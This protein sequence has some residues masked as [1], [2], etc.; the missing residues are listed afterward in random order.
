M[1]EKYTEKARRVIFFSRYEAGTQGAQA[2]EPEHILLGIMRE[3][4]PLLQRLLPDPGPALD[5][6]HKQ[7]SSN[8]AQGPEK[9]ASVDMPLSPAAKQALMKASEASHR[10]GHGRIGPEHLLIGIV[11]TPQSDASRI[12]VELGVTADRIA[13]CIGKGPSAHPW[14][15]IFEGDER[16]D[17]GLKLK[18]L[19]D[20]LERRG[21]FTREE[22]AQQMMNR[23]SRTHPDLLF[24]VLLELLE[25]KK[26]ITTEEARSIREGS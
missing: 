7:I 15:T 20:L 9:P 13:A 4:K 24:A 14:V 5:A 12:L 10:L 23:A 18:R 19:A 3:D 26:V 22:L 25:R 17:L 21:A 11:E 16:A 8:A 2:I 1:F 6:I